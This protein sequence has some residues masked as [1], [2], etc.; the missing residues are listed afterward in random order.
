MRIKIKRMKPLPDTLYA[1]LSETADL[2]VEGHYDALT[3]T[4]EHLEDFRS[5]VRKS[6]VGVYKLVDFINLEPGTREPG[7]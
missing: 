6:L 5:P 2:A 4:P 1:S 3:V 7:K